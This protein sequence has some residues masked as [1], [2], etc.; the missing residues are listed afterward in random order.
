M[1]TPKIARLRFEAA[2]DAAKVMPCK[3]RDYRP[4]GQRYGYVHPALHRAWL[5]WREL[6]V[7]RELRRRTARAKAAA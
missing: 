5:E 7:L 6:F 1:K 4:E 2:I 3:A